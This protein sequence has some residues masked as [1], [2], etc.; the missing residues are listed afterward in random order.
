MS[1]P[2]RTSNVTNRRDAKSV[3][4]RVF[5]GNLNTAL[6]SK[7]DVV[8]VFCAY[9]RVLGCSV[10][11][12]FAFVQYAGRGHARAAVSGHDGRVLAGQTLDVKMAGE[13]DEPDEPDAPLSSSYRMSCYVIFN[14]SASSLLD[15]RRRAPPPVGVEWPRVSPPGARR[16]SS[17]PAQQRPQD[18][19]ILRA[20]A[21]GRRVQLRV[22]KSHLTQIKENVDALLGRLEHV[23]EGAHAGDTERT[24]SRRHDGEEAR[25]EGE[26]ERRGAVTEKRGQAERLADGERSL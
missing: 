5:I 9:G 11:K 19:E 18:A 17:L 2:V 3:A 14:P 22:I 25:D 23:T 4:S 16:P 6:V 1:P 21:T 7:R 26:E 8:A 15:F 12:G 20:D 10:H 24:S 13:P